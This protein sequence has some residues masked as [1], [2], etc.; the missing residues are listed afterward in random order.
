MPHTFDQSTL[1]REGKEVS[2]VMEFLHTCIKLIQD[3]SVVQELQNL[4][5]KYEQGKIDPF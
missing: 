4:I 2:K 5:R 3:E 1:L